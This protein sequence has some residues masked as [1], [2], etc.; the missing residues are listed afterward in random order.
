M[1]SKKKNQLEYH[2][3]DS[4][5]TTKEKGKKNSNKKKSN[6]NKFKTAKKMAIIIYISII[7]LN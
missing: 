2:T 3:K 1:H 7:T 4:H 6:K 5:Q